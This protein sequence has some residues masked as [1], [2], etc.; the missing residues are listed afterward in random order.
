MNDI[1]IHL[2]TVLSDFEVQ[3]ILIFIAY[4]FLV[5]VKWILEAS[6]KSYYFYYCFNSKNN[7][8]CKERVSRKQFCNYYKYNDYPVLHITSSSVYFLC[9]ERVKRN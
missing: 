4:M 2:K 3:M 1:I 7:V 8:V 5:I 6:S 9:D